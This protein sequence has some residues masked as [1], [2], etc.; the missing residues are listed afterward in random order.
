MRAGKFV[1]IGDVEQVLQRPVD[2]YT[3]ELLAAVLLEVP[4]SISRS[5]SEENSL[6]PEISG[7]GGS[8]QAVMQDG[9]ALY[10]AAQF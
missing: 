2:G 8:Y 4:R 6:G 5:G 7:A 10:R 3:K 1:E 9:A